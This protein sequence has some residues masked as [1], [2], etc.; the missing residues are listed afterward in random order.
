MEHRPYS[1]EFTPLAAE[2]MASIFDYISLELSS[3]QAAENLIDKIQAAVELVCDFPFSRPTL[4][5]HAFKGKGYRL[6]VVDNFNLFYAVNGS[7][8]I[9]KR[10][11]Y[12]RRDYTALL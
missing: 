4:N 8:V 12:G 3:P 9:I 6:L 1:Y 10:V 11:I 7:T 2:D 5:D